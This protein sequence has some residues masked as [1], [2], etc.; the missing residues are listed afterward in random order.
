MEV[1]GLVAHVLVCVTLLLV[2]LVS[3]LVGGDMVLTEVCM[4]VV[5]ML[6]DV[7]L[8]GE[9]DVALPPPDVDVILAAENAPNS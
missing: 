5:L 4:P 6:L 7:G 2:V 3:V 1:A 9:V 8:V